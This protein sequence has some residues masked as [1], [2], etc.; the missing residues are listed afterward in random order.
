VSHADYGDI[1]LAGRD[2]GVQGGEDLFAGKIAA[3]AK[4]N[5]CIRVNVG[6]AHGPPFEACSGSDALG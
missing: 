4:E 1:K 5:E 6:G 3:R 2:H